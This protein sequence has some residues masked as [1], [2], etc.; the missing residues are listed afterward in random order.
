M[1]NA[2]D[3]L[4]RVVADLDLLLCAD[5]VSAGLVGLSDAEAMRVLRVA[6][7][8]QRRVDAVIVETVASVDSRPVGAGEVTFAGGFGC[9]TM[10]ELLQRVLRTDA[11]GAAR[12]VKAAKIV[13]RD[14]E[15]S[16]GT[17]LPA[18]WP[19]LREAMLGG[20]IG[21]AGLLAAT[22]PI[23]QAGPRVGA[24]DRWAADAEL[25]GYARGL[26]AVDEAGPGGD[27]AAPPATPDD[28][29]FLAQAI[30]AYLDP[31]GAEPA[32]ERA[33]RARGITLGRAKDGV[34]PIRG[35]LLPEAA[36]QLQRICD[37]YLNPKVDGPPL[38]GVHF[39]PSDGHGDGHRSAVGDALDAHRQVVGDALDAHRHV[40]GDAGD[41]HDSA[42]RADHAF[43]PSGDPGQMIDT[44]TRPQKQHDALAAALN[45]AA[46][47]DDMPRLGGAAP[48]LV[49]S[50]TAEDYAT[51]RGWAHVEG[52][53]TPVP[54]TTARHSACGGS[55]QRV[56]FDPE[57]RIIGIGTTDRIFTTPQRR[58]I[59]LRD[60]EC[61]I[62][63]CHVPAAWCEIHH[64]EEHARGG[65]TSTDNGVALCW[66][67]HR[68]LDTSGWEIRM[69]NGIPQVRGPAWW[70]PHRK[71]RQ[72][73]PSGER[74]PHR[75]RARAH[76]G[77]EL[78][79]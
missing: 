76:E 36:G 48:T 2:A 6:G 68:T 21:I 37:A 70:D 53:D 67:H 23:D 31:D 74:P 41:A 34:I 50:V 42:S 26:A 20:A 58:A 61:L 7:E 13:H 16:S 15:L 32:E 49:I 77:V 65:P 73:R 72:P 22:T 38:P 9:R 45:I 78:R 29:R 17:P 39:V 66:H 54:I 55:V 47:H 46:R 30:V 28:L 18:R 10:N 52:I 79:I 33:M 56:L 8:V 3:V 75:D 51:G 35:A 44:R 14:V 12:I 60:R 43:L 57:G 5:G 24:A 27:E 1:K 11:A 40:V 59:A 19:A 25:A 62:P 69:Q 64:V 4:D 63:G 71:W